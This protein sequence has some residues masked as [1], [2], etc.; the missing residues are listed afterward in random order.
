MIKWE[1]WQVLLSTNFLKYLLLLVK[2]N[3]QKVFTFSF[4]ICGSDK[5]C[6]CIY[7][8]ISISIVYITLYIIQ[9]MINCNYDI[10]H[11]LYI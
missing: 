3:K 9:Y 8:T 1:K 11:K 6:L 2:I 7:I 4:F 10:K 5:I